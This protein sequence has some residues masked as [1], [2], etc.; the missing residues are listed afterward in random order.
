MR[1]TADKVDSL[2]KGYRKE[3][4]FLID[5]LQ[6]EL[7]KERP[8]RDI[9][10]KTEYEIFLYEL[11]CKA[12]MSLNFRQRI[13]II[14]HYFSE[15]PKTYDQVAMEMGVWT[16]THWRRLKAGKKQILA[17]MNAKLDSMEKDKKP[18]KT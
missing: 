7:S 18:D 4:P 13:P 3:Y 8:S 14:S 9:V 2:L 11:L 10:E 17:L 6:E 1:I 12:V 15:K 16:T 5:F